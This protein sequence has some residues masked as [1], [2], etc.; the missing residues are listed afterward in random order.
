[1]AWVSALDR[2]N[3]LVTFCHNCFTS[4]GFKCEGVRE[5]GSR[6]RFHQHSVWCSMYYITNYIIPLPSK[7][8][9]EHMIRYTSYNPRGVPAILPLQLVLYQ[10]I[11]TA[12]RLP[13]PNQRCIDLPVNETRTA[14][15]DKRRTAT[16]TDLPAPRAKQKRPAWGGWLFRTHVHTCVCKKKKQK[17]RN[18][19]DLV[20]PNISG[21]HNLLR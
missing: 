1:M 6:T 9:L 13:M 21:S 20:P 10:P 18:V 12:A 3:A 15:Q 17:R 8:I 7:S 4:S 5:H 19:E 14:D 11:T 16:I 2:C